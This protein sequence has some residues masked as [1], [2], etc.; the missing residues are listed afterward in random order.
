MTD[1]LSP[2][3]MPIV[4]GR[5]Y[6]PNVIGI[7]THT[8]AVNVY[9]RAGICSGVVSACQV[10]DS[11]TD[12]D[13]LFIISSPQGSVS[14]AMVSAVRSRAWM[15]RQNEPRIYPRLFAAFKYTDLPPVI[16]AA[17][18]LCPFFILL[19]RHRQIL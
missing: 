9:L 17:G 13:D 4:D 10:R 2:A 16:W 11:K 7:I 1:M 3:I 8:K 18:F 19:W 15:K 14:S 5:R 6:S 12:Y